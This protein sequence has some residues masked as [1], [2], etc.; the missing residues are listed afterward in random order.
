[1]CDFIPSFLKDIDA[2]NA[3]LVV[4]YRGNRGIDEAENMKYAAAK[5]QVNG[6]DILIYWGVATKSDR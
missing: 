6:S 4:L 1:M 2:T 3:I 5:Y